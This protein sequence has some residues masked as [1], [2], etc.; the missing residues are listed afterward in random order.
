L[1]IFI[2]CNDWYSI[3]QKLLCI[4][5]FIIFRIVEMIF[6]FFMIIIYYQNIL[7]FIYNYYIDKVIMF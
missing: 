7:Y 2:N 4:M 6:I 1:I 5:A 3:F